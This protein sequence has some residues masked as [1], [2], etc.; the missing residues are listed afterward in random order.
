[1]SSDSV[2]LWVENRFG[3]EFYKSREKAKELVES[4]GDQKLQRWFEGNV[5]NTGYERKD[6]TKGEKLKSANQIWRGYDKEDKFTNRVKEENDVYKERILTE[7]NLGGDDPGKLSNIKEKIDKDYEEDV[8]KT[9]EVNI[10]DKYKDHLSK[11]IDEASTKG[12]ADNRIS[13]LEKIEREIIS[14]IFRQPGGYKEQTIRDRI[15][16]K[17][18]ENKG[19]YYGELRRQVINIS[20]GPGSLDQKLREFRDKRESIKTE[21]LSNKQFINITE[22]IEKEKTELK[23]KAEGTSIEFQK[24]SKKNDIL[25]RING[26]TSSAELLDIIGDDWSDLGAKYNKELTDAWREKD[27][28]IKRRLYE[29]GTG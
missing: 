23:A 24:E 25:E 17:I 7:I 15:A 13:E 3:T 16:R 27:F 18:N 12:D 19:S 4:T 8:V 14:S 11:K 20:V 9:L 26:A 6:T 28:S 10:A 29:E 2:I 5:I 22:L 1:M 21:Y